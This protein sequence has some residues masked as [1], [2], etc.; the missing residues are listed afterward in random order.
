M[1]IAMI[2]NTVGWA[3]IATA[4][5]TGNVLVIQSTSLTLGIVAVLQLLC[6]RNS[7]HHDK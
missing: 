6:L 5:S 7:K 4:F 3:I 2:L 1:K